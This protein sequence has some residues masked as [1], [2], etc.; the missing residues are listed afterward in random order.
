[1]QITYIKNSN[2]NAKI[3]Y[4]SEGLSIGPQG[5]RIRNV[6]DRWA[7]CCKEKEIVHVEMSW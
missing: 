3:C 6:R 1:M 4:G 7:E 5:I 2:L